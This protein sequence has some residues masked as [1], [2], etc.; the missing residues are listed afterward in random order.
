MRRIVFWL[1]SVHCLLVSCMSAREAAEVLQEGDRIMVSLKAKVDGAE[2]KSILPEGGIEGKITGLTLASYDENGALVDVQY[3][4]DMSDIRLYVS[5]SG[6]N[7][8]FALANMGDMTG[9]FPALAEDVGDICHMVE[10]YS[11]VESLGIPMCAS[12]KVS[13]SSSQIEIRLVRLFAKVNLRILHTSLDFSDTASDFAFNLCNESLYVRQANG[14]LFPFAQ[15]GSRALSES[16]ILGESDCNPDLNDRSVHSDPSVFGPGPGYHKD[17]T[18]VLYIP[19]NMQGVLLPM[20]TDPMAKTAENISDINGRDYSGIC[21]YIELNAKKEGVGTGV[22]GSIMYRCY[23]GADNMS[24]FNVVRNGCYDVTLDLTQDSFGMDNW[25]VVKGDDWTDNRSLWFLADSYMIYPGTSK[26]VFVHYSTLPGNDTDSQTRPGEWMYYFDDAGMAA[27]G[28]RYSFDPLSL[29]VSHD[30]VRNLCFAFEASEDAVAGTSFP[31]TISLKDGSHADESLIYIAELGDL[32]LNWESVPSYVAQYGVVRVEGAPTETLPLK[33]SV[34]DPSAIACTQIDDTSFRLVA[35]KAG[36]F[37]LVFENSAGTQRYAIPLNVGTPYLDVTTESVALNPDGLPVKL[38]YG[39]YDARG[40]K[41]SGFDEEAFRDILMPVVE[42]NE[43][44]S[45]DITSDNLTVMVSRLYE[46]NECIDLGAGYSLTLKPVK[47]AGAGS[48]SI[49]AYIIDPFDDV[50]PRDYGRIDDYTLFA[51]D[52]VK[53]VLK[54]YFSELRK[55]NLSFEYEAPVPDADKSCLSVA[56]LPEWQ[57]GFSNSNGVYSLSYDPDDHAYATGAS[58]RISENEVAAGLAHSAGRHDVMIYVE[59]RHSHEKI[60]HVCGYI[61]LYVHTALGTRAV[62]GSQVSNHKP[63]GAAAS[64]PTFAGVYNDIAGMMLF[65]PQSGNMI[66]YMD[67]NAEFMTDVSKVY[68]YDCLLKYAKTG[69]NVFDAITMLQPSVADGYADANTRLLYS[70]NGDGG[71]RVFVGGEGYG[72]RKGIGVM[73]YRA[74]RMQT[75]DTALTERDFLKYFLGL[76]ENDVANHVFAPCVDVH[77][78]NLDSQLNKVE[79][80]APYFFAPSGHPEYLD[81]EGN[82]YHVIHFLEEIVPATGGWINLL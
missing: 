59:N 61:D 12:V 2:V 35:L 13:P 45:T 34:S 11:Q 72:K 50:T 32:A 5:R 73:L 81:D 16:D 37:E 18:I 31:L 71:D 29:K 15:S 65:S 64:I 53:P 51:M 75:Y 70:V 36:T 82:G 3:Y 1:L 57:G 80:N 25:K 19:E 24:D 40:R 27:A 41:L 14:R 17:T 77:D 7:D 49:S 43:Y 22:S 58:F 62:F 68:L 76:T 10:S 33:V 47:C 55:K 46:G 69:S 74:L 48:Q 67:V 38:D 30:A 26:D 63:E 78:L 4:T 66:Y 79:R 23:L 8:V 39:F 44:F 20:N 42:D 21:T 6:D 54:D 56:L 28:L 60:G 52:G 9:E